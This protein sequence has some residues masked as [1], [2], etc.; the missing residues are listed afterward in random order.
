MLNNK[1]A[2]KDKDNTL[3][4][5]VSHLRSNMGNSPQ[6]SSEEV[7]QPLL[8]MKEYLDFQLQ[9]EEGKLATTLDF[10]FQGTNS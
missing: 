5:G 2:K 7:S 1:D 4:M 10:L 3:S 6:N 9:K 8:E